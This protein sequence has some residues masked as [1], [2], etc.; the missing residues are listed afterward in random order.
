MREEIVMVNT[1]MIERKMVRIRVL[2]RIDLTREKTAPKNG[3]KTI[4]EMAVEITKTSSEREV[5]N[6]KEKTEKSEM[7]KLE[8]EV[9]THVMIIRRRTS[10]QKIMDKRNK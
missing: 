8:E 5:E 2:P 3:T 1:K 6:M 7:L 4:I 10:L 9:K